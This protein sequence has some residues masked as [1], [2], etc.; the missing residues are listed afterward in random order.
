MVGW[1]LDLDSYSTQFLPQVL[2]LIVFDGSGN[3]YECM[4]FIV[5]Q[6]HLKEK[7]RDGES[8]GGAEPREGAQLFFFSTLLSHS[9]EQ[10]NRNRRRKV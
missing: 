10:H 2:P 3:K 6:S 7:P 9:L 1:T 5:A 4:L 8:C